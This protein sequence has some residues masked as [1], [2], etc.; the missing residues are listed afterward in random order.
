[1][2]RASSMVMS[3]MARLGEPA[4]L[5]GAVLC[6]RRVAGLLQIGGGEVLNG[7]LRGRIGGGARLPL[8]PGGLGAVVSLRGLSVSHTGLA[9]G[10][11]TLHPYLFP[12]PGAVR[13]PP[14]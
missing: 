13:P 3:P 1:M 7:A 8:L 4:L 2:W 6:Q 11:G 5:I 9:P 10:R 12:A 14:G